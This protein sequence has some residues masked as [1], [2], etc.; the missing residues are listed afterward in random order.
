MT[1][2][3]KKFLRSVIEQLSYA[4]ENV[5]IYTTSNRV[6]MLP[7]GNSI[8]HFECYGVRDSQLQFNIQEQFHCTTIEKTGQY[9]QVLTNDECSLH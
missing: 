1:C 4:Q 3:E 6:T 8:M 2:I 7:H 5:Y 9:T